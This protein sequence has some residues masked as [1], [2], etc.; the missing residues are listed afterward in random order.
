MENYC[1]MGIEF[2]F[3]QMKSY[4]DEC[5]GDD[6]TSGYLSEE[7]QDT[8]LKRHVNPYVYHSIIYNSQNIDDTWVSLNEG[9]N[10]EFIQ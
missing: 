6:C 8:T 5:G 3:Y 9:M 7:I 2:H 10:K 1:L 4:G